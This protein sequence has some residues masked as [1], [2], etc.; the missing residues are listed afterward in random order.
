M[1]T[2][3]LQMTCSPTF[4]SCPSSLCGQS[5]LLGHGSVLTSYGKVNGQVEERTPN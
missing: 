1:A 2:D 4:C 5:S 3:E